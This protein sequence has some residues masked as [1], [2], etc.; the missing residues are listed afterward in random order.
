MAVGVMVGDAW[1]ADQETKVEAKDRA[2]EVRMSDDGLM[3]YVLGW[4][5]A[6]NDFGALIRFQYVVGIAGTDPE[7]CE[8]SAWG[9]EEIAIEPR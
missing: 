7:N 6:E 8:V 5:D 9:L 4:V 2:E 3:C 1:A